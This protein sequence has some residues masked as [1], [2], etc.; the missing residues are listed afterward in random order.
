VK[1]SPF[2]TAAMRPMI[3]CHSRDALMRHAW[4]EILGQASELE[5]C[6]VS[7][8]AGRT[9][10]SDRT[11]RHL[12]ARPQDPGGNSP[13]RGQERFLIRLFSPRSDPRPTF[14]PRSVLKTSTRNY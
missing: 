3:C 7:D 10:G 6:E 1:P 11:R 14:H 4:H 12:G 2:T 13:L 8:A 9:S 5:E